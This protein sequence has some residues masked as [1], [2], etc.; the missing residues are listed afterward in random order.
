MASRRFDW[1]FLPLL[2]VL[3][4]CN[5]ET[6]QVVTQTLQYI[7]AGVCHE[8]HC[9]AQTTQG[10]N[11]ETLN[12]IFPAQP[13]FGLVPDQ[14]GLSLVLT[15]LTLILLW[16][17]TFRLRLVGWTDSRAPPRGALWPTP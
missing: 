2:L 13:N 7:V 1:R 16:I 14:T 11:L 9:A 12:L 15:L 6:R 4:T 10:Q 8:L 17:I 5:T 3:L